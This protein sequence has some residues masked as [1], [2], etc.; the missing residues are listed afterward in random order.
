MR[1]YIYPLRGQSLTFQHENSSKTNQKIKTFL[2]NKVW[3]YPDAV[4]CIRILSFIH[5]IR[6]NDVLY[7]L[8]PRR[9]TDLI[10]ATGMQ[11]FHIQPEREKERERERE[12]E[13]QME[14][15]RIEI[16]R[17]R[18]G[19][20]KSTF[21]TLFILWFE[22]G[23][24]T[25]QFFASLQYIHT[26]ILVDIYMYV[27]MYVCICTSMYVRMCVCMYVFLGPESILIVWKM[28]VAG[29]EPLTSSTTTTL[30]FLPSFLYT[31]KNTHI[32]M[33]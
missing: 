6:S 17:E 8:D 16:H 2:H 29:F 1:W 11:W 19:R 14:K 12:R 20:G 32:Y 28:E 15:H 31:H 13:E 26:Y 7:I 22:C 23:E 25:W 10:Q 27:C 21:F 5:L 18:W 9:I 30:Y 33:G 24:N 3:K 4:F